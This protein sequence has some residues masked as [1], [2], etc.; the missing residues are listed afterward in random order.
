MPAKDLKTAVHG[1]RREYLRKAL[2]NNG[3]NVCR[4]ARFAGIHRNVFSRWIE[5]YDLGP[6]TKHLHRRAYYATFS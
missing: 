1:F 2:A 6:F 5:I 4:A 3:G